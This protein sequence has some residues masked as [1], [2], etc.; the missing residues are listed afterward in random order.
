[1]V[2]D[3]M[4]VAGDIVAAQNQIMPA[5]DGVAELL[6]SLC[7]ANLFQGDLQQV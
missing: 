2:C 4:S 1:M 6:P 3:M 7:G 5:A